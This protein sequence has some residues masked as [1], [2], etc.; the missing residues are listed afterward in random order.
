MIFSRKSPPLEIIT[1]DYVISY[2]DRHK[3][4]SLNFK[5]IEFIWNERRIKLPKC[6]KLE[7]YISWVNNHEVLIN[8]NVKEM[9]KGWIGDLNLNDAFKATHVSMIEIEN[10]E[11]IQVTILGN[12]DWGDMG[13]D[14]TIE[15]GEITMD[16][17][18]D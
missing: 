17:F 6:E 4:W 14:L 2:N 1:P 5:G 15:K 7:E 12:D 18:G 9:L 10:A 11:K 16:G 3:H 8:T 13:Y